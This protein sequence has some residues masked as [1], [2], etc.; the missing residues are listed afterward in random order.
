MAGSAGNA[1][2]LFQGKRMSA[3]SS[4]AVVVAGVAGLALALAGCNGGGR[5]TTSG[6]I[7]VGQCHVGGCSSEL[8]TDKENVASPCIFKQ[9]FAC[10]RS[11]VCEPQDDGACGWSQTPQLTSCLANGGP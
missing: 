8:C 10:Y 1:K 3:R 11:A 7:E 4:I 5:Q 6:A 9:E 2:K